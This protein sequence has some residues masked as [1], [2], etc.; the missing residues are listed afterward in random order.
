[1]TAETVG[2]KH[3]ELSHYTT[4]MQM[5]AGFKLFGLFHREDR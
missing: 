1:M 3:K 4:R 2:S 5:A